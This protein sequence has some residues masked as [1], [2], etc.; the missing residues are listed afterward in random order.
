LLNRRIIVK[1]GD[2]RMSGT[3]NSAQV[4]VSRKGCCQRHILTVAVAALAGV[5]L[6]AVSACGVSATKTPTR[7]ELLH[8]GNELMSSM[9]A[10]RVMVESNE[11]VRQVEVT[12][13]RNSDT[14]A[15]AAEKRDTF[16][17]QVHD[18]V[19]D[20]NGEPVTQRVQMQLNSFMD[21]YEKKF[22]ITDN[23]INTLD[24]KCK[25]GDGEVLARLKA[26]MY[27]R[28]YCNT[29]A[30]HAL[31]PKQESKLTGYMINYVTNRHNLKS[32]YILFIE[33][34]TS[35]NVKETSSANADWNKELRIATERLQTYEQQGI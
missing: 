35:W 18:F 34:L 2:E 32:V 29:F 5:V 12:L 10:V 20:A 30:D 19:G 9:D 28:Q 11:D 33:S 23:S 8:V 31:N 24:E 1:I 4:Y 26:L 16:G 13:F 25:N 14:Q 6:L 15:G 3:S 7:A 22:I 27:L 21:A 17:F